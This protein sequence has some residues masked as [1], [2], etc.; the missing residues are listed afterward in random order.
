MEDRILKEILDTLSDIKERLVRLE[1]KD[2]SDPV[3]CA[4]HNRALEDYEKRLDK[5][6]AIAKR[7]NT[8]SIL[9][10]SFGVALAFG[11]KGIWALI[12]SGGFDVR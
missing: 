1:T 9:L 10:G 8:F 5:L 2:H 6:E 11:L 3:M 7:D 4:L 12:T